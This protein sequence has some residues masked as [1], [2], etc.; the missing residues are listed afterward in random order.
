MSIPNAA[1]RAESRPVSGGKVLN[2]IDL[3][4]PHHAPMM[5][6]I[7]TAAIFFLLPSITAAA[8]R[9][10]STGAIMVVNL[11]LGWS[12]VGWLWALI[13]SFTGN[14]A[15]THLVG[16]TAPRRPYAFA[17]IIGMLVILVVA[18][19]NV[20]PKDMSANHSGAALS[21]RA[22]A[23]AA[24][25]SPPNCSPT[26]EHCNVQVNQ[27][28]KASDSQNRKIGSRSN[29]SE[30]A[31]VASSIDQ[32]PTSNWTYATSRDAITQKLAW[33]ATVA[34]NNKISLSFPYEGEQAASL[35]LR[36]HPQYGKNVI[37]QIDRGQMLCGLEGCSVL[38]RFDNQPAEHFGAAPAA[39]NST[40]VI[41]IRNYKKFVQK[42]VKAKSVAI[43]V[44]FFQNGDQT[45]DFDIAGLRFTEK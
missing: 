19:S 41:F 9:H 40:N 45:F 22:I 26:N 17:L 31:T 6:F 13:W 20:S 1:A 36:H 2:V 30:V 3:I 39:D 12:L 10:N 27:A 11:L 38:V 29:V 21:S 24:D 37:L 16:S 34:S 43:Q 14:V 25:T 7:L 18:V 35:E 44:S 33:S 8:R 5:P 15:A 32:V 28:G 42:A 23:S 4:S